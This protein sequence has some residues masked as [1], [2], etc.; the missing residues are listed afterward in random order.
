MKGLR[1]LFCI[2]KFFIEAF[3][4]IEKIIAIDIADSY[5]NKVYG[6]CI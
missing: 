2:I 5:L 4:T 6:H 1:R 3:S